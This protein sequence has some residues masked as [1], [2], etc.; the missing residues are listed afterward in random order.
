MSDKAKV[1]KLCKRGANGV[2]FFGLFFGKIYTN[3]S[4]P[5]FLTTL[6][7]KKLCSKYE[8]RWVD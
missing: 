2:L 4:I 8:T 5:C 6:R 3:V 7:L 1:T